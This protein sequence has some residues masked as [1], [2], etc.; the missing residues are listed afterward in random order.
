VSWPDIVECGTDPALYAKLIDTLRKMGLSATRFMQTPATLTDLEAIIRTKPAGAT[1]LTVEW[2]TGGSTGV[3]TIYA[4]LAKGA[5]IYQ[6]TTGAIYKSAT[7]LSAVYGQV[8]VALGFPPVFIPNAT[9]IESSILIAP[10][11]AV[12]GAIRSIASP[13]LPVLPAPSAAGD[14]RGEVGQPTTT[15]AH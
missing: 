5:I 7:E 4:T 15:V 9:L 10:A 8:K 2:A 1:L 12:P 14:S 11:N 13:W 3:H 6:D